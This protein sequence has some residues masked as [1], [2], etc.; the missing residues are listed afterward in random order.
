MDLDE[1]RLATGE[2][3]IVFAAMTLACSQIGSALVAIPSMFQQTLIGPGIAIFLVPCV[4]LAA[5]R[6]LLLTASLFSWCDC[7]CFVCSVLLTHPKLLSSLRFGFRCSVLPCSPPATFCSNCG[8]T[9]ANCSATRATARRALLLS[10]WIVRHRPPCSTSRYLSALYKR[11]SA[12]GWW[13][14]L[15]GGHWQ[16]RCARPDCFFAC[17][18]G[19]GGVVTV[20]VL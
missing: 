16:C 4:S 7:D 1:P 2:M 15:A 17:V 19:A 12:L 3:S 20:R 5:S 8:C 14:L 9:S 13:L 18:A 6:S 10:L 11:S